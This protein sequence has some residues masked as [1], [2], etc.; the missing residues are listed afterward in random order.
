[1]G[2]WCESQCFHNARWCKK[3][4]SKSARIPCLGLVE[5]LK[6]LRLFFGLLQVLGEGGRIG[7]VSAVPRR[8]GLFLGRLERALQILV[9]CPRWK[10]EC[11]M[12]GSAPNINMPWQPRVPGQVHPWSQSLTKRQAG[13]PGTQTDTD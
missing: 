13:R 6:S 3:R 9:A 2:H 10:E 4:A 8:L 12:N 7:A 5:L 1:M 11:E